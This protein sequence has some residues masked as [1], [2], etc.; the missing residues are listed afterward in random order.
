MVAPTLLLAAK[1]AWDSRSELADFV[2]NVAVCLW[3]GANIT[4]MIGEFFYEDKTR[5]Y[6]TIFFATGVV[7][8]TVYYIYD[9]AKYIARRFKSE[10]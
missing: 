7:I 3:I 4:W 9:V 2:H 1:I 6:A 5:P 10:A 8:L